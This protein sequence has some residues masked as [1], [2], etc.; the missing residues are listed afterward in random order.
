MPSVSPEPA[1]ALPPLTQQLINA[2]QAL[3]A[4]QTQTDVVVAAL[5]PA[6]QAL[7]AMA[8]AVLLVNEEAQALQ[9]AGHL[10]YDPGTLTIWQ[11]GPLDDPV[12]AADVLRFRQAL[13]FE[14]TGALN[15][16]YPEL[17]ERTGAFAAVASAVL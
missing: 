8:G 3:A 12:P 17:E 7:E 5:T 14:D 15:T 4:A 9:M 13:Y 1:G 2:T 16:A 10:G 6:L 11:D